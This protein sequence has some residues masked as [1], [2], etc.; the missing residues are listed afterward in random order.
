MR[1]L[2]LASCDIIRLKNRS[3]TLH[4][5]GEPAMATI[6]IGMDLGDKKHVVFVLN[7]KGEVIKDCEVNNT[8][9]SLITLFSHYPGATIAIEAGTHSAWISR[10]LS[11]LGCNVLVGNPRKLRAIWG[12]DDK[13]DAHDAEMLGRIARFDPALL[14]PIS[15]RGEQAQ[16]DL[17]LLQSRDILVRSRSTLINHVRGS[18]KAFG[19]RL[20]GCS[21]ESFHKQAGENL[22]KPL[23]APLRPMLNVIEHLTQQIREFDKWVE[24]ICKSQYQETELLREVK[25]VGPL[26]ALTYLLVLEDPTRFTKSRQVGKFLGLTPR[27]DQSGEI[28]KQL[29]IT[30]AGHPL[31]RRLLV[32]A[33]QYILGPFGEDCNLRRFG[34]RL[35]EK[36]GKNAKRR[37]VVA[38]ARKLAVLLHRIWL[39]GEIYQPLYKPLK[40]EL[41]KAA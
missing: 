31:L 41:L 38:V 11:G 29:R 15:H 30:K 13:S 14:Y 2:V 32:S 19:D 35:C 34:L 5:K 16:I 6:T 25:G 37:A 8:K 39:H 10:L 24:E 23:S 22:P 36:G 20:P 17:K 40:K 21:S 18:V 7:E 27:R 9:E 28:D 4:K 33:S 12:S 1:R 3:R 26:T